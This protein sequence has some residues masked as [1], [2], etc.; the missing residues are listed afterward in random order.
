MRSYLL[1]REPAFGFTGSPALGKLVH[2]PQCRLRFLIVLHI[3]DGI[4][5]ASV[6]CQKDRSANRHV[7]QHFGIIAEVGNRFDVWQLYQLLSLIVYLK[8]L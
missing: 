7:M 3:Y 8:L 4:S 5:A 2:Q 6:L 1:G